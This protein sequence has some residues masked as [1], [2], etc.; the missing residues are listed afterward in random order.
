M[1]GSEAGMFGSETRLVGSEAIMSGS[2]TRLTGRGTTVDGD[3]ND[4]KW[5]NDDGE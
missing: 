1:M 2:E 3:K 5:H 4:W